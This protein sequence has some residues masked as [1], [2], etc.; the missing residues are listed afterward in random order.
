MRYFDGRHDGW[1]DTDIEDTM[2]PPNIRIGCGM[3][4]SE[5][6]SCASFIIFQ[7]TSFSIG[8]L[9]KNSALAFIYNAI[10]RVI[11]TGRRSQKPFKSDF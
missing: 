5:F 2:T 10:R 11:E 8:V 4:P 9:E 7:P 1:S 6:L 3:V